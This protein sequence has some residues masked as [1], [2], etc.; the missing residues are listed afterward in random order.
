MKRTL[1]EVLLE[2]EQLLARNDQQRAVIRSACSG[3]AGPAAMVDRA[4]ECARYLR[5]HP[6]A[7]AG[8]VG[9]FLLL[10]GRAALGVAARGLT[11]WRLGLRVR[12]LMR[13]F[14]R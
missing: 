14:E 11:L 13:L 5:A 4:T 6:V 12:S 8:V 2:R 10:R 1:I 7:L 3:L 9:A